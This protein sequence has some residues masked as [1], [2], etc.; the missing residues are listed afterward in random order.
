M[1]R[2]DRLYDQLI[3]GNNEIGKKN[4]LNRIQNIIRDKSL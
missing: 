2:Q 4:Y 3:I 1:Y